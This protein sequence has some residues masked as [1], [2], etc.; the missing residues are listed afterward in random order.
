MPKANNSPQIWTETGLLNEL[1]KINAGHHGHKI[2]FIL[3]AGA[4][5]SSG[6]PT[7][8]QL[9]DEWLKTEHERETDG[10]E[11]Y[12]TWLVR[13]ANEGN[14][15]IKD[16]D[17]KFPARF[18]PQIF[19]R[20]FIGRYPQAYE[21]LDEKMKDAQ[22]GIGYVSLAQILEFTPHKIVITT[23]FD[24]LV[25]EALYFYSGTRPLI[26]G[27][28]SLAAFASANTIRPLVAKIHRDLFLNPINDS[29]TSTLAENWVK[30]LTEIFRD[31]MPVVLG[32]GGNDGSLMGFLNGLS[33]GVIHNTIYWCHLAGEEL[34][35]EVLEVV[36]KH[37]GKLVCIEGFD[38]FMLKLH[39]R[40]SKKWAKKE[41]RQI[42]EF[43]H[44]RA[45]SQI[46]RYKAD[47]NM[48][49]S[50]AVSI[51][52]EDDVKSDETFAALNK[53]IPPATKP[54]AW[55]EWAILAQGE[56]DIDKRDA[57][58]RKG[59]K[60]LPKSADLAGTYATFLKGVRKDNDLAQEFFERA[61]EA[62]PNH[63][64]NLGKYA[65][66]LKN[67]RKDNDRAEEFYER[68]I[69]ADPNDANI[70]G[71][72]ARFLEQV[73]K[74][75]DRAQ[76]FYERAVK[77]NPNGSHHLGNYAI[78]LHQ[79]RRDND[80]A[81][82][83]YERAIKSSPNN[84][85]FLSNYANF[86]KDIRKD[87]ERAQEFYER[88]FKASPVEVHNLSNYS[89]FLL[90]RGDT[91]MGLPMLD[92]AIAKLSPHSRLDLSVEVWF[93]AFLHRP[94]E[95][96]GTAL[97][98]L[99]ELILTKVARS[100]DSDFS[101]NVERAIQAGHPDAEWLPKLAEVI[102]AKAEPIILADW[103]AWQSA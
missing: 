20:I 55:W 100:P 70:L 41:K 67:V 44:E 96:H 59:L 81:Q 33:P 74:D 76:K 29:G 38:Q 64:G 77:A 97:K 98:K 101:V 5:V 34:R 42:V 90:G 24:N 14:K 22:P 21:A 7:G 30:S 23:N 37:H 25:A 99:R 78:F 8:G 31:H 9:V 80:H 88:A 46:I 47:L 51:N 28:E 68:A 4:S 69:K 54:D 103:P 60:E 52:N 87:N 84:V 93:F 65:A 26:C 75:N 35:D 95:Q 32:Y 39:A 48:F 91:N 2:C 15:P 40:F 13:W 85:Y 62:D 36:T 71:S 56:K 17:P 49:G 3:G 58:Y 61:I 72:Y 45:D 63:A 57:I 94:V 6:V 89:G 92:N 53:M 27:H 16:F 43:I 79:I 66:F 50:R 11:P 1:E 83:F 19:E 86:L 102:N 10:K 73:C 12:D 18:Y 82:E